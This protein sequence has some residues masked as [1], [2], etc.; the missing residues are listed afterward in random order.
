MEPGLAI[1]GIQDGADVSWMSVVQSLLILTTDAVLVFD[2]DGTV[3]VANDAASRIFR[4]ATDTGV[5]ADVRTL[6]QD[7]QPSDPDPLRELGETL[8]F[9][10]DATVSELIVRGSLPHVLRVSV[11]CE[12]VS[13]SGSLY[14]LAVHAIDAADAATLERERLVDEL[15]RANKRLTGTLRIV[16]GTLDAL[17]IAELFHRILGEVADTLDAGAALAYVAEA[18]G[19]RLRGSTEDAGGMSF[20]A[21]LPYDHPLARAIASSHTSMRLTMVPLTREE[22]REGEQGVRS[23]RDVSSGVV[24]KVSRSLVLPFS[25]LILTPVWFGGHMIC[26]ICVGWRHVHTLRSDDARLLDA[27][28]EYLSVQLAGAL[29]AMR[30]QYA[31]RLESAS[32]SLRERLLAGEAITASL[33]DEVFGTAAEVLEARLTTIVSNTHQRTTVARLPF[34]EAVEVPIDLARLARGLALP[35]VLELSEVAELDRWVAGLLGPSQGLLVLLGET[36]GARRAY[37]VVRDV[38]EDSFEEIDVGF[39]RRLAE[40]VLEVSAG[41]RA[42]SRDKHISQALMSGMRNELQHVEGISAESSYSSATEAA[43]VRGDFFDRVRL[44]MRRACVILGDVSGKGVEAA[45]V[46]SAVKTAL[47]AYAFEGLAP[48]RMVELLNDFLL[49]FS[50]IETFATLFVGIVDVEGRRLA[51]CSAGHPPA[52]LW[53]ARTKELLTLGVQSGVVGAF[54]GMSYRDGEVECEPGDIL[55][56]Y[57]DGVTEARSPEGAFFGEDGL[58]EVAAREVRRG[59]EGLSDRL[60]AC[61]SAFSGGSLED[62]VALLV[63]RF[64]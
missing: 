28:A 18:D 14:L 54:S 55:I 16:L 42:R 35:S 3:I 22:L 53:R 26:L 6:F 20:P 63:C 36:D 52:L 9:A 25:S 47:S 48:S 19:Y 61:V 58:R 24:Y 5:G 15:S 60:L 21:R 29:A 44:P 12:R 46:S 45:S 2:G 11:R 43:S 8:P 62:D 32:S 27:V 4:T 10:T 59:F 30:S 1:A 49:G 56:L 7:G 39:L 17:D 31:E 13:A 51:Y 37:L 64:D 41:E 38:D 33:I 40:D 50:R 57:T 23:V 34:A